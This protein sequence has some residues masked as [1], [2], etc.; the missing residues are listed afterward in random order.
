MVDKLYQNQSISSIIGVDYTCNIGGTA[1]V[2][3]NRRN[4]IGKALVA[5]CVE[6]AIKR[7]YSRITLHATPKGQRLFA[8]CGFKEADNATLLSMIY[9]Q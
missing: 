7:Q 8:N 6:E 5:M 1:N 4:G 9:E 2:R 3:Q